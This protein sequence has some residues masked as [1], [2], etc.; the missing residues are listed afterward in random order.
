MDEADYDAAFE[1]LVLEL[2]T[3]NRAIRAAGEGS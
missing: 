1:E 2:A 3:A